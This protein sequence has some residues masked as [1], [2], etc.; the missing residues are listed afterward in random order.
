MKVYDGSDDGKK[1]YD[2]LGVIG[3]KIEAGAGS[4]LDEASRQENLQ[5]VARWP[6]TI[7]YFERGHRP[8]AIPVYTIS[9]ELYENGDQPRAEA[10][11]RRF[12]PQ[13]RSEDPADPTRNRLSALR[14][15]QRDA[16]LQ[17]ADAELVADPV[18]GGFHVGLAHH[19][20]IREIAAVG[21]R[22]IAKVRPRRSR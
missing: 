11:L 19:A 18:D 2:T 12:R 21:F 17:G 8:T 1:I 10:R 22:R 13:R 4:N 9:F 14:L 20:L 3:R 15:S 7:S 6:M 5:K 16:L